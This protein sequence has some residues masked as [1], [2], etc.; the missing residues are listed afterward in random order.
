MSAI[1]TLVSLEVLHSTRVVV[2]V[3]RS[4]KALCM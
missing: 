1:H 2:L 4:E 3:P